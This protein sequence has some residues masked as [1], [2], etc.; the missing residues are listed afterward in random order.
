MEWPG[1]L[2]C[3]ETGVENLRH[4]GAAFGYP[5][6]HDRWHCIFSFSRFLDRFAL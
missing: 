1:W 5:Y 4:D 3:V 2:K 6:G